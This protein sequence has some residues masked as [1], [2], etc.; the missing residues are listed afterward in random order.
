MI[1]F[2]Y[3]VL[4]VFLSLVLQ[5][6]LDLLSIAGIKPDL[7][8][9]LTVYFAFKE[10]EFRGQLTGFGTGLLQDAV[11]VTNIPLGFQAMPKAIIGFLIGKYG[12]S[13]RG[14]SMFSLGLLIFFISLFQGLLQII[15]A[16]VFIQAQFEMTY[17]V[18][19]PGAFYNS[20]LGP[21]LFTIY[22]KIFSSNVSVGR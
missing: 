13:V 8:L 1:Y 4:I 7:L 6:Y 10:G 17:R 21:I 14:D 19:I 9:I 22:D 20:V 16:F 15:L 5:G 12:N 18:M 3:F 2:I 11:S